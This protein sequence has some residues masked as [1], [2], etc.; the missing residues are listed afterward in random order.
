MIIDWSEKLSIGIPEIDIE[1][2]FLVALV[3][4]FH[5]RVLANEPQ[6]ILAGTFSQLIRY[7]E[8]H[9]ANEE[10]LMRAIGFPHIKE[11]Q[12]QHFDLA[13]QANALTKIYLSG[14][15]SIDLEL[16]AFL[17]SWI[18]HHV[19]VEDSKISDFL[20]G[21]P[22][23]KDW[24]FTPAFSDDSSTCFKVC[25]LCGKEWRKFEDFADDN[26]IVLLDQMTDRQNH[27]YNLLLF[28]CSCGTTLAIPLFDFVKA[29]PK[30]FYLEENRDQPNRPDYCLNA[31][32]E[33]P[34]LGKCA[35]GY[36]ADLLDKLSAV[37]NP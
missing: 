28:N 6:V 2:K 23:P 4:D 10:S 13:D 1:H 34:C 25:T 9:F 37:K 29:D 24:G 3:N 21:Q 20:G 7:T 31:K 35:C 15:K 27:F 12:E 26:Q 33:A 11:H 32:S 19:L 8:K 17:K 14:S 22:L 18:L 16:L 30:N 36:T 5:R